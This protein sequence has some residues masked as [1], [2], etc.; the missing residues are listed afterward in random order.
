MIKTVSKHEQN[1]T[2]INEYHLTSSIIN[3]AARP[4]ASIVNAAK[5][6]GKH[7]PNIAATNTSAADISIVSNSASDLN[8]AN[9]ANAVNTAEPMA[10]PLPV[11]AVVFPNASKPS[12]VSLHIYLIQ[13]FL[14]YLLHYLQ[15][16]QMHQL[17]M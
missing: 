13:P 16:D 1:I 12:V 6:Y 5:I 3:D 8:A 17:L 10:K 9:N 11:A 4:T 14:Q 2:Y 15:Q 7:A